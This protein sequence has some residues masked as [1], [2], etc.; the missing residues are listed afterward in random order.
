MTE[1]I[2][3][4]PKNTHS[5]C[6]EFRIKASHPSIHIV[7]EILFQA[8]G[9]TVEYLTSDKHDNKEL[10]IFVPIHNKND[11]QTLCSILEL[12]VDF[13]SQFDSTNLSHDKDLQMSLNN[14]H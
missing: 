5:H 9:Q 11:F 13:D 7:R 10:H 1:L 8:S 3:E 6:A 14:L 4:T 2:Q 12:R